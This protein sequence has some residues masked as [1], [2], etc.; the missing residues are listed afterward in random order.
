M[1]VAIIGATG[2]VGREMLKDL[3]ASPHAGRLK[4]VAAFASSKSAGS[5]VE[6]G[7]STLV[8]EEF[9]VSKL[10]GFDYALM[11]AGG[12]FSR[13]FAELIVS[14]GTTVIDNSSAWRMNPKYPLVVPEVNG[15]ILKTVKKPTLVA[16]PNCSTIQLVCALKPLADAFGLK[17]VNVAT[18]QSVS[19]TGNKGIAELGEQVE[20]HLRFQPIEAK[21]YRQPIAFNVLPAI[22]VIDSAGHCFEEEKM[23]RETR[24]ILDHASLDILATTARVPTIHCHCE[25]VTV[26]LGRDVTVPEVLEC[27]KSGKGLVVYESAGHET[28]PTPRSVVGD[29]RVHISRVRLPLEASRS[30]KVQFW[31]V[32][33]NLKKGASTNAVQI[34][35][36]FE[37]R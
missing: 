18:Y 12:A 32:A 4:R 10:K 20:K 24:R 16:N 37:S 9:S 17:G 25:A 34:L 3:S 14:Q 15:D 6:F 13:E 23:V 27:F 19:G 22:D 11:S 2:A 21:V 30:S 35:D 5:R 7:A 33:D 8:V 28:F 29:H 31:I 26:D 1:Q 36:Q